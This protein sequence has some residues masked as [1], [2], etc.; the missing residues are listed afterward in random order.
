MFLTAM[1]AF[2]AKAKPGKK[3]PTEP[4]WF[5]PRFTH[6]GIAAVPSRQ[7]AGGMKVP[8]S[9]LPTRPS[10]AADQAPRSS[11]RRSPARRPAL[12]AAAV[13]AL[14]GAVFAATSSAAV[15]PRHAGLETGSFSEFDATSVASGSLSVTSASAAAGSRSATAVYSGAG[16][17][18]YARGQYEVDWQNGESVTYSAAFYLPVGFKSRMQ[19]QVSLMRWDNWPTYGGSG[20][21][22]GIVIQGSDKRARLIRN[23]YGGEQ[24]SLVGP[25]DLPEGRWFTLTVSQRLSTTNPYSEVRLDGQLIGTSTAQNSYG[26]AVDRVRYGIV[27][28]GAGRQT[29][30]LTLG[31]D[32][33]DVRAGLTAPTPSPRPVDAPP[34]VALT[35]PRDGGTFTRSLGFAANASDDR[36]VAEVRFRVDGVRRHTDTSAP[37][38]WTWSRGGHRLDYG[39]HEVTARAVDS[40]GQTTLSSGATVTKV[41]AANR[42]LGR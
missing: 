21:V 13:A 20:D 3:F 29:N 7:L 10:A 28:I 26:R 22:G 8:Q 37:Y 4:R 1:G 24:V 23:H 6:Y 39:S 18:G 5:L 32:E 31:F 40:A 25:F 16:A 17:N 38:A 42:K 41:R 11:P 2:L 30:S 34:T 35:A 36:G 12:I 27:S 19:S 15:M 33:A 14:A 9:P